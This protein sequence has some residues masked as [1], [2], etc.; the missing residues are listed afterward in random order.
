ML[1]V[2]KAAQSMANSMD[3]NQ[4]NG[5]FYALFNFSENTNVTIRL[6]NTLGQEVATTQ[7]FEGKIGRVR[8]QLDNV[9]EGVYMVILNDGKETITKKIV[10]Q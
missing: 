5:V 6:T 4:Q 10:K 8:L 1:K 9:A 3:V 2:S 7:Q